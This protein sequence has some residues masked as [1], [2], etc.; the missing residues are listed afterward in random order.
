MC[1]RRTRRPLRASSPSIG[2][3]RRACSGRRRRRVVHGR[4]S[5]SRRPATA[6]LARGRRRCRRPHGDEH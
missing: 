1:G 4:R 2:G 3:P 6:R 5:P